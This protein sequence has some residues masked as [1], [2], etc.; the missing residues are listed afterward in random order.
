MSRIPKS[1]QMEATGAIWL[2]LKG[3]K[4]KMRGGSHAPL[5]KRFSKIYEESRVGIAS[6]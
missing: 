4:V 5:V 3:G 1:Q 2:H 6:K